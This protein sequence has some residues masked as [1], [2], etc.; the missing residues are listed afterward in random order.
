MNLNLYKSIEK[1]FLFIN[2]KNNILLQNKGL[3]RIAKYDLLQGLDFL[4]A[5][6]QYT[7][8]DEIAS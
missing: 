3:I 4:W 6:L 7:G 1:Y 5:T 2:Q 8:N